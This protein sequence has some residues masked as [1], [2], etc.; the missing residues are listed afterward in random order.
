MVNPQPEPG[1]V[2][3]PQVPQED[4]DNIIN[5]EVLVGMLHAFGFQHTTVVSD[6]AQVVLRLGTGRDA[7]DLILMDISM[8]VINGYEATVRTTAAT[9]SRETFHP[10]SIAPLHSRLATHMLESRLRQSTTLN[11]RFKCGP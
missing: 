2:S 8:P 4:E 11:F 6:G 7:F 1:T 5:Q 9:S 3:P 10:P